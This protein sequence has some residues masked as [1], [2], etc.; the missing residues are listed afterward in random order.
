MGIFLTLATNYIHQNRREEQVDQKFREFEDSLNQEEELLGVRDVEVLATSRR[1][2]NWQKQAM[3]TLMEAIFLVIA[4]LQEIGNC[5]I[6]I[7][8][9]T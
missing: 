4:A 9:T 8:C 2:A 5:H 6:S 1:H 3:I 7:L